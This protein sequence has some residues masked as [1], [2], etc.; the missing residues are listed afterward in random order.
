MSTK[1]KSSL[2]DAPNS[3]SIPATPRIAKLSR[4]L[5]K[6]DAISL[7]PL[8]NS[9]LP[10]DK[11]PRSVTSKP[12]VEKRSPRLST[13]PDKKPS[14]ILKPSEIQAELTVVQ[15]DLKKAKDMLIVVE[16]EKS[17]ALDKLE[18]AQRLAEEANEKLKEAA[19]AQKRAEENSE[20]EKFRAV[21]MEQGG[22][23]A[24]QKKEEE[25]QRKLEDVR[26]QHAQD[27]AALLT[28][29]EE[30]ERVKQELTMMCD[31]KKQ[32]L[33]HAEDVTKIA[34]IQAEKVEKLSA[35]LVQ[36]KS[37]LD[38]RTEEVAD[39]NIQL[40]AELKQEIET[41]RQELLR[42]SEAKNQA[43]SHAYDATKIAENHAEKVEKLSADIVHL[44]SLLDSK[45]EAEAI[46]N[47]KVVAELKLEIETLREEVEK[48]KE[49]VKKLVEYDA[50]IEQLNIDLE[51]AK[52]AMSYSHN[53]VEECRKRVV[54]LEI[55]TS[56]AKQLERSASESM[57]SIMK[58]LEESNGLL[59]DAG[60]EIS[61]LKEK[62]GLLEI[63]IKR[64]KEDFE[65]AESRLGVAK[66]E[67]SKLQEEVESLT[68][69]L[70]DV[71]EGKNQALNNEKLAA[72]SIQALVEEKNDIITELE[73]SR[74]EEE[75]SKK[76]MESL[77]S[78]LHELSSEAREAKEQLLSFHAERESFEAQLEDIKVVLETT[79][80]KYE[81][82]LDETKQDIDDLAN[83]LE[84]S[85]QENQKLKDEWEQKEAQLTQSVKV[86]EQKNS[87]M[88]K[89]INRLVNSLH[90]AEE[91][92]SLSLEE[93]THFKNSIKET[94]SEVIYLK[95]ALGGAK[96]ESMQLKESLIDKE[97]ELQNIFQENEMLRSR[98]TASLKKVE[99][100]TKLLEEAS[101]RKQAAE[102]DELSESEKDYDMLPKV[103]EFSEQNG[104]GTEEMPKFELVPQ[105]HDLSSVPLLQEVNNVSQKETVLAY[106]DPEK[107]KEKSAETEEKKTEPCNTDEVDPE[108]Y[109]EKS[110]E[111]E[112][113]KTDPHNTAE[114]EFKMWESCKIEEK[115]FS[116]ESEQEHEALEDDSDSKAEGRESLDE[117]NGLTSTESISNGGTS[118]VKQQSQK[119]KKPLLHKFG[120]LLKKKGN[121][122][123][124][125]HP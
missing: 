65:E 96:A 98:D 25:W 44:K 94:E 35:E 110:A 109:K 53:L 85:K 23:E 113:K 86:Y 74:D 36:M 1:T 7:S 104:D 63:S 21:E 12:T 81:H 28:A 117:T 10:V 41:L 59:R 22:I 37:L 99:E 16:K 50:T 87:S 46:E 19:V 38:S 34:E 121:S 105:Q 30:I 107:S 92:V 39:E 79:N 40:V 95:D 29:T 60:S 56:E 80:E 122:T 70:E 68:S 78:A 4:G 61:S 58:Q 66:E 27:V 15:E 111:T 18:E 114:A 101:S 102:N 47:A 31:A 69:E 91:K 14:R 72:A 43:L 115:D 11:S 123:Q 77:A 73:K 89:E 62:I 8:Q 100:L 32:A 45:N 103:V 48:S 82:M 13:P 55:Q 2:S 125:Q 118:P 90:E 5:K 71:K 17:Q 51:A 24:A 26:N 42:T 67:A 54:E 49:Y 76:A 88:E 83:S 20:I 116:P 9:R 119:K 93:N 3:K 6:S 106:S 64:Q 120:S 57:E 33:I 52:L 108:K 124:K 112:K 84:Q 97:N 75:K